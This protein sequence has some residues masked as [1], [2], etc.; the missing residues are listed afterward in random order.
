MHGNDALTTW[1]AADIKDATRAA[2]AQAM[3][4]RNSRTLTRSLPRIRIRIRTVAIG[5]VVLSALGLTVGIADAERTPRPGAPEPA[6]TG[7]AKLFRKTGD[8][9]RFTFDAHGLADQAHG[10]FRFEHHSATLNVTA[11]G[12]IDCL[13][14]GGSVAV[15]TGIITS[16]EPAQLVGKRVGFTVHDNGTHDRL[17]YSWAAGGDPA[18]MTVEKCLSSAPIETVE[19]GNLVVAHWEPDL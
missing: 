14:S 5:V 11:E 15:A 1:T 12:R 13:L 7:S 3:N 4:F 6:L 18:T 10:T 19:S 9:I 17:G 16:A 8:D 2:D